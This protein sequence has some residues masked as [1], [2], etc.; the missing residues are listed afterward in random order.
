LIANVTAVLVNYQWSGW[1]ISPQ[2]WATI[3]IVIG[4]LVASH[5]IFS[6]NQIFHGLVV[7]WA[8]FGIYYKRNALNDAETVEITAIACMVALAIVV[9]LRLKRW[10]SY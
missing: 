4:T 2:M 5:M 6:R 8:L 3:M 1:G 7:I 9:S 10:W